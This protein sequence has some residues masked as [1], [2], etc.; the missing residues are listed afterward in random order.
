MISCCV[1][2]STVWFTYLSEVATHSWLCDFVRVAD[3]PLQESQLA[4][5]RVL[6]KHEQHQFDSAAQQANTQHH[7]YDDSLCGGTPVELGLTQ[8]YQIRA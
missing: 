8:Y 4:A 7:G 5:G 1:A 2:N 3:L 6:S